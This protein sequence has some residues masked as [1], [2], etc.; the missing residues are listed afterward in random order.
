[1]VIIFKSATQ[2]F[3]LNKDKELNYTHREVWHRYNLNDIPHINSLKV[4][5]HIF[6][7]GIYHEVY[8][9]HD[10]VCIVRTSSIIRNYRIRTNPKGGLY[11]I[12]DEYCLLKDYEH[13]NKDYT[14]V[15][16]NLLED[17]DII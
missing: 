17:G 12:Y 4:L 5:Y 2:L 3:Y 6:I 7:D 15:N 1:M 16:L 14:M 13:Y 11:K 8:Y 9:E 10:N